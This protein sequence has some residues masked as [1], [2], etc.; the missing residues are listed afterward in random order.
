[1]KYPV[2]KEY[3]AH[4]L[5]QNLPISSD[6]ESFYPDILRESVYKLVFNQSRKYTA[7]CTDYSVDDLSQICWQRIISKLHLYNPE[8]S[9]FTTWC[10]RVCGSILNKTYHKQKSHDSKFAS[11]PEGLDL[12]IVEGRVD[13][14]QL[15][16]DILSVVEKLIRDYPHYERVITLLIGDPKSGEISSKMDVRHVAN[17]CG[18]HVNAVY[19]IITNVIRPEFKEAML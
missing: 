6:Y 10:W 13:N 3:I 14:H 18:I 2:T 16:K 5:G 7:S 12:D 17:A 8:L 9:K 4:F 15:R 1:M 11:M 19:K